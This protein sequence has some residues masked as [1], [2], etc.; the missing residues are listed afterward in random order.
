V[1]PTREDR[2]P[3]PRF[4]KATYGRRNVVKRCVLWPKECRRLATRYEKPA[5]NCLAM[6]KLAMIQRCMRILESPNRT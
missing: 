3:N 6:A 4:E 1:I 2:R 5:V